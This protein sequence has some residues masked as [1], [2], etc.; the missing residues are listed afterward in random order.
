MQTQAAIRQI[1][2]K[3]EEYLRSLIIEQT[4][5]H[6]L[7]QE[8]VSYHFGWL[9]TNQVEGKRLR[10]M[11][12]LLC[13][14]LLSENI[15]TGYPVAAALE[16]LHNYTLIHDDIEDNSDTR[17]GQST[18]WKKYGIPQA[19]NTGDFLSSLAVSIIRETNVEHP[20]AL[21]S[22]F[23]AAALEVTKGQ[24]EDIRFE[25]E[26][27]VN[28]SAYLQMISLKTASLF[29]AATRL[30]A[31]SAG[32][33]KPSVEAL[34]VYGH[35]VGIAFQIYDDYL[36]I[37]GRV[38]ETGKP[39]GIDLLERKKTYPVILGIQK[40]PQL[41]LFLSQ[42]SDLSFESVSHW[43]QRLTNLGLQVDTKNVVIEHL[44]K[45]NQQLENL[46]LFTTSNLSMLRA[47]VDSLFHFG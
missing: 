44:T 32:G 27:S 8:M 45:A 17:H 29:R 13:A 30:G 11:L 10:P 3:F 4:K 38:L 21:I 1:R 43:I 5:S 25:T 16:I 22:V 9:Q 33:D 23:I 40:E 24:H 36:G 18:L 35:E 2:Q 39:A 47:F 15:N 41:A 37:W 34:G 28:E 12:A 42:H 14:D 6:P 26:P 19:I 46:G 20:E 31:M 7:L